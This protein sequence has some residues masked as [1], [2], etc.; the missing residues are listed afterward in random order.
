MTLINHVHVC[1]IMKTIDSLF[2]VCVFLKNTGNF[3]AS[4]LTK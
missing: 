2:G 3:K 1:L 4:S